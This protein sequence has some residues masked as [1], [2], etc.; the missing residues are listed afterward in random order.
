[1]PTSAG[2]GLAIEERG[3]QGKVFFSGTGL[4]SIAR[5]YLKSGAIQSIYFWDPAVI[6]KV[7]GK[8]AIEL[9]EGRE[10]KEGTNLGLPG[11]ESLKQDPVKKNLFYGNGWIK[12][13]KENVDE[14]DF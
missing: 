11:F 6:G 3:L 7:F 9:L 2:A 5:Q 4:P 10:I 13:T 1:M 14:Y 12:V 8:I